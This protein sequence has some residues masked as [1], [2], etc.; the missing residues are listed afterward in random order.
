MNGLG[1]EGWLFIV[2]LGAII[3][4]FVVEMVDAIFGAVTGRQYV[5]MRDRRKSRREDTP[6]E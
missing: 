5:S 6:H 4:E 3:A 2:T 1:V